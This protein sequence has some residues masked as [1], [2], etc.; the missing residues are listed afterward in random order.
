MKVDNHLVKVIWAEK[1][2]EDIY[3]VSLK[4]IDS[5][6][7]DQGFQLWFVKLK[8]E[9]G[10]ES[11]CCSMYDSTESLLIKLKREE[12]NATSE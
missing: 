2:F 11:I 3:E 4:F 5:Y 1:A 7:Y 12:L 9:G 8:P 6:P 10:F